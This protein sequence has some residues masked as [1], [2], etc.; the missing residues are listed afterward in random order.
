MSSNQPEC[1]YL[2]I[3]FLGSLGPS[4]VTLMALR[5]VATCGG[6]VAIVIVKLKLLPVKR[7]DEI[8]CKKVYNKMIC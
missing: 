8:E 4:T 7:I 2:L 6:L 5:Y 1:Q 3:L